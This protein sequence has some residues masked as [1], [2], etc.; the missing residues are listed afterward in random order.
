MALTRRAIKGSRLTSAEYDANLDG[1]ER[2]APVVL[3]IAGG[4]LNLNNGGPG[5]YHVETEGGAS[6]DDLTSIIGGQ[7]YQWAVTLVLNTDGR[8]ITV[9]HTAP[10]LLLQ[11]GADFILNSVN[12]TITFRD[13][14]S[15]IWREVS[16]CNVP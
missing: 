2:L 5:V 16:R 6:T 7:G 13:R 10:N 14:T 15:A 8:V 12:D 3:T 4:V 1:L 11:N 9:K